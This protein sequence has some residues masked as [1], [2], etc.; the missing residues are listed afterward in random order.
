MISSRSWR[1]TGW[2]PGDAGGAWAD[3]TRLTRKL[4]AFSEALTVAL[5][6][7]L[8]LRLRPARLAQV[9]EP[10]RAIHGGD[11]HGL[12]ET[13]RVTDA[14][15]HRGRPFVR[16][17]CLTRGVTRYWMMRRAGADVALCFGVGRVDGSVEAHCWLEMDG[18]PFMEPPDVTVFSEMF[19]MRRP[20]VI[21]EQR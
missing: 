8:L 18:Q 3:T 14:A 7:P 4:A 13:A 11:P 1:A 12:T 15:L 9:L 6:A 17:G 2:L 10:R 5:A 20:G 16:T 19:R 21:E